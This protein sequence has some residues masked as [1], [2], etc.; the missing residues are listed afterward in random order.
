MEIVGC[1]IYADKRSID[2]TKIK[3]V[4]ASLRATTICGLYFKKN[5]QINYCPFKAETVAP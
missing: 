1:L 4:V 5:N 2:L 3:I